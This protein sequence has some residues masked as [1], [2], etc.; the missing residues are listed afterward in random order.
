[1]ELEGDR[2]KKVKQLVAQWEAMQPPVSEKETAL[3]NGQA[4]Q[5]TGN[6]LMN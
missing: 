3:F 6:H 2:R 4:R 1:M 5:L